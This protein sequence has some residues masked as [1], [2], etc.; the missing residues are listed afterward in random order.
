MCV[1]SQRSGGPDPDE[2]Q[3]KRREQTVVE[4]VDLFAETGTDHLKERTGA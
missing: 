3:A 4:L 2:R 1:G